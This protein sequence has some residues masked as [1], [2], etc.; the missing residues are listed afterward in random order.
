MRMNTRNAFRMQATVLLASSMFVLSLFVAESA[1][2]Q[3]A[4]IPLC[5]IQSSLTIG[6]S[7][8]DVHCLQRYLNWAGFTVAASGVG[9]SG[10]ETSYFGSLTADAVAR[11]QNA[12]AASVLVPV[13]LTSGSGYWG[14]ASFAHYVRVVQTALGQ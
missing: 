5:E 14:S 2:A 4:T 1:H 3:T 11:W 12:N 13:G 6:S 10:N 8:E 9:S 7:G